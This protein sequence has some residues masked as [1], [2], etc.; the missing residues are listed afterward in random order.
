MINPK[1]I[2]YQSKINRESMEYQSNTNRIPVRHQIELRADRRV[3]RHAIPARARAARAHSTQHTAVAC[4]APRFRLRRLEK[5]N[6]SAPTPPS[7]H[8]PQKTPPAE[9]CSPRSAP[10]RRP[11]TCVN[12]IT[13]VWRRTAAAVGRLVHS[14]SLTSARARAG[15][16]RGGR[17][18]HARP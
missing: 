8:P 18:A 11:Q 2:Q 4:H 10:E 9:P 16:S 12:R 7:G 6:Q 15:P 13:R 17:L 5:R 14:H 3:T 1:S